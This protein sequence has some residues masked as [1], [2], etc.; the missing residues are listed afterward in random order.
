MIKTPNINR[1]T[2][3]ELLVVISIIAILAGMLLPALNSARQ[4]AHAINCLNNLKQCGLAF[5][6]YIDDSKDFFPPV[7]GG[8]YGNPT[9][10]GAACTQWH[11]YLRRHGVEPKFVRCHADPTVQSGFDDSA[12]STSTWDT[13][14]SYIY[15]GMFAFD[16]KVNCLKHM[17]ESVLLSERSENTDYL[18]HHGYP[19]F[20][21]PSEWEAGI[22]AIRHQG[23]ANYLY[24]DGHVEI[25]KFDETVGDS[26]QQNQH[27]IKEYLSSYL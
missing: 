17:T 15:N 16:K 12:A 10:T 8:T 7:H 21:N 5:R 2:L 24:V 13:R 20:K 1:F 18:D 22:A 26:E 25:K 9:R 6:S 27:F 14:P 4:K 11:E 23:K 19:A 3:I